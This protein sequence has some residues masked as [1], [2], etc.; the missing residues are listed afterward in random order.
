MHQRVIGPYRRA[1]GH[2]IIGNH[3]AKSI[4]FLFYCSTIYLHYATRSIQPNLAVVPSHSSHHA[5]SAF[6]FPTATPHAVAPSLQ[7]AT[8][9][10]TP[11]FSSCAGR[12]FMQRRTKAHPKHDKAQCTA[13]PFSTTTSSPG[14]TTKPLQKHNRFPCSCTRLP[15]TFLLRVTLNP[16]HL[17]IFVF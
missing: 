1:C 15:S 10:K 12:G 4:L 6:C 8:A 9:P 17:P 7:P 16:P 3:T 5:T 13:A 11:P 14:K 2:R